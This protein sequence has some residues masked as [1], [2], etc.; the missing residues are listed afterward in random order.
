[1]APS[2]TQKPNSEVEILVH[3]GAP[4]LGCDDAKYRALAAAY[5]DFTLKNHISLRGGSIEYRRIISESQ[6]SLEGA[7][8]NLNSPVLPLAKVKQEQHDFSSQA[9]FVSLASVVQDSMPNNLATLAGYGSPSRVLDFYTSSLDSSPRTPII[10]AKAGQSSSPGDNSSGK[11]SNRTP[12]PAQRSLDSGSSDDYLHETTQ[13][14]PHE[15]MTAGVSPLVYKSPNRVPPSTPAM[16]SSERRHLYHPVERSPRTGLAPPSAQPRAHTFS[17]TSEPSSSSKDATNSPVPALG[18]I[19]GYI[20]PSRAPHTLP[21]SKGISKKKKKT[22]P[23]DADEEED[24]STATKPTNRILFQQ[25]RPRKKRPPNVIVISDSDEP[26]PPTQNPKGKKRKRDGKSQEKGPKG[27]PKRPKKVVTGA[28]G[29]GD[30]GGN[31]SSTSSSSDEDDSYDPLEPSP[32]PPTPDIAQTPKE[33]ARLG[34]RYGAAPLNKALVI[35]GDPIPVSDSVIKTDDLDHPLLR[36]V[37]DTLSMNI[38]YRPAERNRILR[39]FERGHWLVDTTRW[40]DALRRSCWNFLAECVQ[41]N[42]GGWGMVAE[43]NDEFTWIKLFGWGYLVGE[44]YMLL[45]LTSQ[46]AVKDAGLRWFDANGRMVVRMPQKDNGRPQGT[47]VRPPHPPPPP[48]PGDNADEA[49]TISS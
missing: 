27:G 14:L 44:M 39:H 5:S 34:R 18:S 47:Q 6:F 3:I 40:S 4:A 42:M 31:D 37:I 13:Y 48:S 11:S 33:K 7:D 49:I 38:R 2:E 25:R 19:R 9:S 10:L 1:M 26:D 20:P 15:K 8:H 36:R 22:K 28:D 24:N 23:Q 21:T 12:T 17:P 32:K 30:G 43:R 41:R 29:G 35:A 46:R 16:T 45:Y